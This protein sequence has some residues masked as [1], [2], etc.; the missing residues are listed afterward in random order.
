MEVFRTLNHVKTRLLIWGDPF[1]SGAADV[2]V[3]ITGNPGIIDFYTEFC[4][5]L[6]NNTKMPI[7]MLGK[8]NT[9]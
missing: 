2:I 4:T 3:C 1:S 6:Y 5:E 8:S 9:F 7:C